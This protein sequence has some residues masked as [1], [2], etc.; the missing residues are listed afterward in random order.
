MN[1]P[2]CHGPSHAETPCTHAPVP[3]SYWPNRPNE[4]EAME[5]MSDELELAQSAD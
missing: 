1:C 2:Y 5:T 3:M 4:D